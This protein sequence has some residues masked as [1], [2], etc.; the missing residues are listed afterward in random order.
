MAP[1]RLNRQEFIQSLTRGG[2]M[3]GLTGVAV[4]AVHGTREVSECFNHNY[5]DSCWAFDGCGLPEKKE[6]PDERMG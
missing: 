5:C 4:A 3:A 2:L 6:V 1:K